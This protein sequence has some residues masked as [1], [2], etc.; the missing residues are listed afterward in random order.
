[1]SFGRIERRTARK[2]FGSRSSGDVENC[3][4]LETINVVVRS[5]A[6]FR[7]TRDVL[8]RPQILRR[9]DGRHSAVQL[10]TYAS[11]RR[12]L[13][14]RVPPASSI[15]CPPLSA[16]ASGDPLA[17]ALPGRYCNP[18]V[19]V[20]RAVRALSQNI[21]TAD[22]NRDRFRGMMQHVGRLL[23]LPTRCPNCVSG[24]RAHMVVV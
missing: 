9:H 4:T 15:F 18:L 21:T 7:T 24:T 6:V 11:R 13:H 1:M 10:I 8:L 16:A 19:G 12:R 14:S 3:A 23:R 2:A 17:C 20:F 22:I 5:C